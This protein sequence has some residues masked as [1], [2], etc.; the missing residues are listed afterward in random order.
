MT[1]PSELL[2]DP[3]SWTKH[4]PARD[5]KGQ[6]T[7]ARDP[8][9]VCWCMAGAIFRT[10]GQTVQPLL[11]DVVARRFP[12]RITHD[13]YD[14]YVA[15]NDHPDTTHAEVLSVLKEANL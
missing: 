3:T 11:E 8:D 15:F 6:S 10:I 5:A 12:D 2:A 4:H 1:L 13:V 7:D 14:G 9:A